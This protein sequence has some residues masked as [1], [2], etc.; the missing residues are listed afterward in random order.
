MSTTAR[1]RRAA[2]LASVL[3]PAAALVPSYVAPAAAV[4]AG[5]LTVTPIEGGFAFVSGDEPNDIRVVEA[6]GLKIRYTDTTV[7]SVASLPA[8]CTEVAV[9]E[10]VRVECP[11]PA[12]I[13][14]D[15]PMDIHVVT[16]GGDDRL[17][18]NEGPGEWIDGHFRFTADLG[19]GADRAETGGG[20]DDLR[21]GPGNDLLIGRIG[22]DTLDGGDGD[23]T[24]NGG[25]GSDTLLGGPGDDVLYGGGLRDILRGGEDDDQQYGGA[26]NDFFYSVAGT[27]L[28]SGG[29]DYDRGSVS[30]GDTRNSIEKTYTRDEDVPDRGPIGGGGY[31]SWMSVEKFGWTTRV[32][33]GGGTG[34]WG[35]K[36][37]AG[38]QA[39]DQVFTAT[40]EKVLIWDRAATVLRSKPGT[41][42]QRA[43]NPGIVVV[44][45]RPSGLKV[46][47]HFTIWA[48]P[49]LNSDRIDASG[50]PSSGVIQLWALGDRGNEVILGSPGPDFVWGAQDGDT[51]YGGPGNDELG[52]NAGDDILY[53]GLGPDVLIGA[54]G[55]DQLH[56]DDDAAADRLYC[57]STRVDT[58]YPGPGD[59]FSGSCQIPV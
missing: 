24:V 54:D 36:V 50:L 45:P 44:C 25:D 23:D 27:D 22:A 47:G 13:S 31:V 30:S 51:V 11:T 53:G 29:G 56:G 37:L 12:G 2:V 10:G 33:D 35:Y 48:T 59:W 49:R 15:D 46:G 19:E 26:D 9:A 5:S 58:A 17:S 8:E 57:D 55:V 4:E 42:T 16:G 7:A 21:G 3:A 41:C 52:G 6:A 39:S 32:K 20:W 34:R 38:E 18:G 28:L 40:T 14:L 1:A 43:G